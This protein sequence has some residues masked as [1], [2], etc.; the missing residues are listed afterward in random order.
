MKN[1]GKASC[2]ARP[3]TFLMV[4]ML[5]LRNDT[6]EGVVK[7]PQEPGVFSLKYA[8]SDDN[9]NDSRGFVDGKINVM[10]LEPER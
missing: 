2:F 4:M 9:R 10:T 1:V 7:S 3:T 6:E 5:V 8:L